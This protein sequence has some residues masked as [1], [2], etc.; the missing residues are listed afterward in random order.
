MV[1][2]TS[3]PDLTLVEKLLGAV[4]DGG[5]ADDGESD[6][7]PPTLY[8]PPLRRLS[9]KCSS[10]SVDSDGFPQMLEPSSLASAALGTK[11]KPQLKRK[12]LTEE[13]AEALA[14][15]MG[16]D[17]VDTLMMENIQ[18]MLDMACM[19]EE[20]AQKF[21]AGQAQPKEPASESQPQAQTKARGNPKAKVQP[22]AQPKAQAQPDLEDSF[23]VGYHAMTYPGGACAIRETTGAKKQ[24]FQIRSLT[25]TKDE[26]WGLLKK[27]SRKL[28]A[29]ESNEAV[30]SW[31]Q[32]EA[33]K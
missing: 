3:A 28:A 14:A 25:K 32:N 16:M 15:G 13:D 19:E 30:K 1:K 18:N 2:K 17:D 6:P 26:L 8:V 21:A 29:G 7:S 12:K 5:V 9:R 27:A 4:G 23:A 22:K 31:A 10:V 11:A 33:A 24:L 20:E